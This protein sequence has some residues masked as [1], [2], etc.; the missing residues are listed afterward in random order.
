MFHSPAKNF[1]EFIRI[2]LGS[3]VINHVQSIKYLGI[4]VDATLSWKPQI[5]EL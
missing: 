3:K 4:L 2:K 5:I 1:N